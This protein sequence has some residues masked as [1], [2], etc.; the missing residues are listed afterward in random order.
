MHKRN[1]L[2][3]PRLLELKRKKRNI[4]I[5][6]ISIFLFGF[7]LLVIA[8]SYISR[9]E[10]LNVNEVEIKG[11][12]IIET[13][14]IKSAVQTEIAG[15]YVWLF[16]KTNIFLYPKNKIKLDLSNQFKRLKDI[17]L[18]IENQKTLV[19]SVTERIPKYTWCGALPIANNNKEKCYFL[20]ESG[21]IFDEAPYFSGEVYF[22]FY[23]LTDLNNGNPSGS[24][25]FQKDFGNLILFKESIENMGLKPV[26]L[27]I[28]E[29]N[30][31]TIYLS[32]GKIAP[33]GPEIIFK[34]D[35]DFQKI[36]ENLKAAL[37]TE[38]LKSEF[39]NKYSS[40]LYIDLRFENKVYY[41]F[42]N[43][44]L[45]GKTSNRGLAS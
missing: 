20:D 42:T 34:K 38:P 12:K 45:R 41:K 10:K 35:S 22:K 43:E 18:S 13:E 15:R 9:I 30:D 25:F 44:Q 39:K 28:K 23:G 3:S 40:L 26:I 21:Y 32:K 14:A 16:P 8:L 11:N 1:I 5:R 24:Y 31:A 33:L 27:Y 17:N 36:A 4:F 6:K 7:L 19:I 29:N 37:E 2:N